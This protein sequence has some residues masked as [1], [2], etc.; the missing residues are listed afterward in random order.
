MKPMIITIP[1]NDGKIILTKE[2][3]EK[4]LSD[5]YEQG[6]YDGKESSPTYVPYTPYT[7]TIN[8]PWKEN[9]YYTNSKTSS[10]WDEVIL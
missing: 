9:W 7:P 3:L 5:A 1:S 6:R 8:N 2:E 4:I 10:V